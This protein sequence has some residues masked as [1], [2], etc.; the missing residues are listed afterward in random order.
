MDSISTYLGVSVT[1]LMNGELSSLVQE[2]KEPITDNDVEI[3]KIMHT[4]DY[5]TQTKVINA[6][7]AYANT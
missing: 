5:K 6:L 7:R 4:L 1:Y 3:I 2:I